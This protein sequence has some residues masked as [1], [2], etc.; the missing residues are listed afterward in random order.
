MPQEKAKR[1]DCYECEYRRTTPGSAHSKCNHPS[2]GKIDPLVEVMG[3]LASVGRAM[4]VQV[5]NDK[6]NIKG[7][8]HGI[9]R[10]WFNWP[11]N[12]DPAWLERCDGFTARVSNHVTNR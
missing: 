4:P 7:N 6:L 8:S 5:N 9:S 3:I 1:P 12:F 2:I 10:G 11:M